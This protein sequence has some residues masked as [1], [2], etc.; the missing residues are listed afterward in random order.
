M[1][2][3]KRELELLNAIIDQ[4]LKHGGVQIFNIINDLL[5]NV[6]FVE[7]EDKKE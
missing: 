6:Q 5:K 2:I 1:K 3:D 4:A 7:N